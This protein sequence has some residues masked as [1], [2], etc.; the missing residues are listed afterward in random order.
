MKVVCVGGGPA[1]LYFSILMKLHD[2]G[3][4]LSVLERNPAGLTYGWGVVFWDDLLDAVRRSDPV[5]A[6]GMVQRSFRWVDQLV[7]VEGGHAVSLGG[8]RRAEKP[9]EP[10]LHEPLLQ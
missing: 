4:D 5:T 1:G 7:Q 2:R 8:G 10:L 6:R 9:N 3:H